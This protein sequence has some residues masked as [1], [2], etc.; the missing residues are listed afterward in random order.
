MAGRLRLDSLGTQDIHITGSPTYSHFSGIFKK[1]TQFAFDVRENPLL[2][3]RFGQET[4][5]IIP[6]DM[7]DLLTNLTLRYKFFS[8]VLTE[9]TITDE[10]PFTPNVGIHAIEYADLFIGGTH[11]ERLT[12][13]WIYLYHKY[14]ASDYNFRDSIVP[15]TT[16]KEQPYGKNDSGE[17][18]LRQMYID[19]PFYF[20]N[21]LPASVLLCKLDKH[22][23]YVR[24]K[25]RSLDKLLRPYINENDI[26]ANI[27]TASLLPTYAYLGDDEL[28]YLKSA[29]VDQLIT[30]PRV[31]SFPVAPGTPPGGTG[32]L[33]EAERLAA[34]APVGGVR[35][36]YVFQGSTDVQNWA[37]LPTTDWI[38]TNVDP[39]DT[40]NPTATYTGPGTLPAVNF[41][42]ILALPRSITP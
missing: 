35:Y 40:G 4:T 15:L 21:N 18:K 7:G 28:N 33:V 22:D 8:K 5:C 32:F 14:H 25:F 26:Q 11:I 3:A 6:V 20:Y 24:I 39:A 1:H 42:R 41:F 10:D 34:S 38:F 37:N 27:Q 29:P 23:C 12:G 19:L 9:E 17:W 36:E 31:R 30:Q 16:A 13:D 2:D